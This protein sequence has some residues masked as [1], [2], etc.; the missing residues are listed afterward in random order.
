ML[1]AVSEEAWDRMMASHVLDKHAE[2]APEHLLEEARERL[3]G[4]DDE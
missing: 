3:E 1:G 4:D 2:E